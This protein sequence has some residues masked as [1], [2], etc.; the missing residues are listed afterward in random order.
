MLNQLRYNKPIE[1]NGSVYPNV[2]KALEGLK[3]FDGMYTIRIPSKATIKE[4]VSTVTPKVN[5]KVFRVN[6]RQYMTKKASP[7]FDFMSKY[8][9]DIPMP[10]RTMYGVVLEETKGMYKMKLHGR[11]EKDS[12]ICLKCGRKLTHPVS[13]YYGLG[14][15]CGEHHHL[16]PINILEKLQNEEVIFQEVDKRLRE[17]VWEGWIIK[18]AILSMD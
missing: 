12:T 6:V 7:E 17:T 4:S 2:E 10:L 11:A 5:E 9:N 15:E 14:P 13:K 8:N 1:V 16:A 18:T 3:G